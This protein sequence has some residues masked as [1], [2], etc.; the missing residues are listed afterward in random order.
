MDFDNW[1]YDDSSKP[2]DKSK[3]V[4]TLDNVLD[5]HTKILEGLL[6]VAYDA[7]LEEGKKQSVEKGKI[8]YKTQYNVAL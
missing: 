7:G 1:F 6:R 3:P 5:S 4:V 2:L 8:P